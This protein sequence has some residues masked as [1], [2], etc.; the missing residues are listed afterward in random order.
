MEILFDNIDA[1]IWN[2]LSDE[3]RQQFEKNLETDET[4]RAELALRQLE[5]EAVQLADKADLRTI[6]KE[7]QC[8]CPF[9][10][11]P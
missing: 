10:Q 5:N 11:H 2:S 8:F 7:N 6:M 4:L 1:Y 9:F 3:E